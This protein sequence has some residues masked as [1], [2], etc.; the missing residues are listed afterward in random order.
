MFWNVSFSTEG[1]GGNFHLQQPFLWYKRASCVCL[2]IL[3]N[4]TLVSER[5][6]SSCC[7]CK[8][9]AS[10]RD[11]SL[12]MC[13]SEDSAELLPMLAE[14]AEPW[15]HFPGVLVLFHYT[16]KVLFL[17][18]LFPLF[19]SLSVLCFSPVFCVSPCSLFPSV[20]PH[21]LEMISLPSLVSLFGLGR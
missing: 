19:F 2:G 10:Q 9:R 14:S 5:A 4:R 1:W 21:S 7:V 15:P 3:G 20:F 12:P 17:S 18:L 13:I 11:S 6:D 16:W 8:T